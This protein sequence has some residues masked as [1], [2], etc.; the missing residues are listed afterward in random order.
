MTLEKVNLTC[1]RLRSLGYSRTTQ[2]PPTPSNIDRAYRLD[3]YRYLRVGGTFSH[4][5]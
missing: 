5:L 1:F 3:S 2:V 4:D